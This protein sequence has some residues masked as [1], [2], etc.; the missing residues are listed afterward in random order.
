[1]ASGTFELADTE[2][3]IQALAD[4]DAIHTCVT[5]GGGSAMAAATASGEETA[6]AR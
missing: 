5:P 3:A 4:G 2:A 6:N 1:M